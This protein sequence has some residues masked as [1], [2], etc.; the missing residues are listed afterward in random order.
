MLATY[1]YDSKIYKLYHFTPT[2]VNK[3]TH[4]HDLNLNGHLDS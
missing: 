4:T 3:T 2:I 1:V